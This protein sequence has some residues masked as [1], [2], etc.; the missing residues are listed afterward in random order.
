MTI[1]SR[2]IS[3]ITSETGRVRVSKD[4]AAGALLPARKSAPVEAAAPASLEEPA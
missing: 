4:K 2:I 3:V 1:I